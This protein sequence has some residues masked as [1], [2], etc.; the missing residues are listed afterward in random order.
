MSRVKRSI[1][2]KRIGLFAPLLCKSTLR[3]TKS[4]NFE[5]G[6]GKYVWRLLKSSKSVDRSLISIRLF[7][8][9][10]LSILRKDVSHGLLLGPMRTESILQSPMNPYPQASTQ[11]HRYLRSLLSLRASRTLV[12][13]QTPSYLVSMYAMDQ[14]YFVT[15]F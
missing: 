13:A 1:G 3:N 15:T 14:A 10:S 11:S 12:V 5:R 7:S 8:M 9:I 2:Y 6:Y 4:S